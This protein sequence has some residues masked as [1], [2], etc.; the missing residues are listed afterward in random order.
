MANKLIAVTGGIGSGKSSVLDVLKDDGYAV[1][2]CD[3]EVNALYLDP[4]FKKQIFA[5][6]PSAKGKDGT[7]DKKE[8]ARLVFSDGE[9]RRA[10]EN[11]LHAET[12]ARVLSRGRAAK[13]K[14]GLVFIEVPLLF[15]TKGETLFDGV[16]VVLREKS[17]R[18]KS[19]MERSGLSEEETLARIKNQVDYESFDK[20]THTVLVND[21]TLSSLRE[22]V[23][24]AVGK[25]Q[26]IQGD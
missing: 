21:G 6:F 9:K 24:D 5:L 23:A 22:K 18:I 17:A 25:F 2:S 4:A 19:V 7:A 10:L 12:Y 1:F 15:E 13:T 20:T 16:L 14:D 26:S 3:E 11:L 8:I